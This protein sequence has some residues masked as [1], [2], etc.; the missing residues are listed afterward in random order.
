MTY[1]SGFIGKISLF[2]VQMTEI[3][4]RKH[5]GKNNFKKVY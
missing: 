4:D 1:L 2:P 5:N 3:D